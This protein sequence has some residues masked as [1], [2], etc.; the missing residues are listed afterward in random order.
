M[1]GK[2]IRARRYPGSQGFRAGTTSRPSFDRSSS[3]LLPASLRRPRYSMM[4][5]KPILAMS[6]GG[7]AILFPSNSI[8]SSEEMP[9][10]CGEMLHPQL[11]EAVDRVWELGEPVVGDVDLGQAGQPV[12]VQLKSFQEVPAEVQMRKKDE[13]L[14]PC[15]ETGEL[16]AAEVKLAEEGEIVYTVVQMAE[17]VFVQ[18]QLLQAGE[19]RHPLGEERDL[20]RAHIQNLELLQALDPLRYDSNLVVGHAQ[21]AQ[22]GH[23]E[24]GSGHLLE[25]IVTQ[26][27]CAQVDE[28]HGLLGEV[29]EEVVVAAERLEVV[30]KL[31]QRQI[32]VDYRPVAQVKHSSSVSDPPSL[33]AVALRQ[34]PS[35]G[36]EQRKEVHDRSKTAGNNLLR[37]HAGVVAMGLEV[38]EAGHEGDGGWEDVDEVID[39]GELVERQVAQL[40]R[41][42]VQVILADP[43]HAQFTELGDAGRNFVDPVGGEVEEPEEGEA[44]ERR[45]DGLE[46]VA[47]EREGGDER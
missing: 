3:W 37:R 1:P 21:D 5:R 31:S 43:E 14:Q 46:L 28:V 16:V 45:R 15:W 34:L 18:M 2:Q 13:V 38:L 24:E 19:F 42:L 44:E 26:L 29:L 40:D 12:K 32:Q 8:S 47:D 7:S 25:E 35:R 41:K 9:T 20:V 6:A 4:C 33:E 39:H 23:V 27:Q 17:L 11:G 22:G 36:E 10:T 30:Q